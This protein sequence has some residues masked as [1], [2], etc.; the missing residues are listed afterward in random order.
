[1]YFLKKILFLWFLMAPIALAAE[2]TA[3]E[4]QIIQY[5]S[6]N[7]SSQI[8]LLKKLVN[9][10]SGTTN[11]K[12]VYKVGTLMRSQLDKLG[13]KTRWV[14]EPVSMHRAPT[15]IAERS[16]NSSKK[17][18]LIAHLDTVFAA[19][20]K[21]KF[22][23]KD[24]IAY[25]PGVLDNKAGLVVLLYSL[26]A[27]NSVKALKDTSITVVLTGDEEDSGKPVSIS[28]KPLL[29]AAKHVDVALDFEGAITLDTATVSRRGI[30]NW[31][32]ES[33]GN[34]SHS[35]T[36]FQEE[37]G[38]GAIFEMSRVLDMMRRQL[39][40]EKYLSFN[41]GLM[42]GGSS[43]VNQTVFGKQNVVAKVAVTKGDVRFADE[44]QKEAVY[45]KM[46]DIV[47]QHLPGTG[48]NISF[49]EGIPSMPLTEA[50]LGLL[51][52]Y[53]QVSQDL[54]EGEV[55]SL[56]AGL[57]G[58]GDISHIA[59]TVPAN[60]AGLGGGGL[61]SHTSNESLELS[62]LPIQTKR[63]ALFIYRLSEAR[64]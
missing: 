36:I 35:A 9:I 52:Q 11:V 64:E 57:R 24:R 62:S 63:A 8:Q 14:K 61:G 27:L 12:G 5:I 1:M 53:S 43:I 47:K 2:L 45:S 39:E 28:R 16:G 19:E 50:N 15:L 55:K 30:S 46:R 38:D 20:N 21:T 51:K 56:P 25:G 42:M 54:G 49:E 34:E 31:Q 22:T 13:F 3:T 23:V 60:L 48:S 29:D 10:N 40:N 44:A 7:Q 26:K 58:A 33:H 6:A 4:K 59:A 17:I 37:V 32:I 41:P 18:I